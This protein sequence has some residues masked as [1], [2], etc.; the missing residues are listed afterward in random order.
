MFI[1][2]M[3]RNVVLNPC[4]EAG[5]RSLLTSS[6]SW[7]CF[8]EVHIFD[9]RV[10]GRIKK[11]AE[12]AANPANGPC[13]WSRDRNHLW[14]LLRYYVV[15]IVVFSVSPSVKIGAISQNLKANVPLSVGVFANGLSARHGPICLCAE[16]HLSS[17]EVIQ[18]YCML[19]ELKYN[20]KE[21]SKHVRC[22]GLYSALVVTIELKT[23]L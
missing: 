14:S 15:S 1:S 3:N 22:F 2:V 23:Y 20:G 6:G 18:L 11:C 12:H 7:N 9:K 4:A 21:S 8:I 17:K 19:E 5:N 10:K 16:Q 13:A